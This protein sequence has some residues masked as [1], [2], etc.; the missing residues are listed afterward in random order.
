[1]D[2][3]HGLESVYPFILQDNLNLLTESNAILLHE[4]LMKIKQPRI[5]VD[6]LDW[7]SIVETIE[8]KIRGLYNISM[9]KLVVLTFV[10]LDGV[11]QAPG[12]KGEDPSGGFT[13][14]GW[15]V[16]FFDEARGQ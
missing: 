13:L 1:M 8:S 7:R 5:K 14:E 16:P 9:R 15:T 2:I 12:G 3:N 10:S 6:L 11:M 4:I